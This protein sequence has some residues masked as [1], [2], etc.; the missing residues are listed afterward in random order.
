MHQL[1]KRFQ[2]LEAGKR[3]ALEEVDA[4]LERHALHY[5]IDSWGN[6]RVHPL[7]ARDVSAV[8]RVDGS[9][10]SEGEMVGKIVALYESGDLWRLRQC[11]TEN[12]GQWFMA[13]RKDNRWHS[14][15]CRRKNEKSV[16]PEVR[17]ADARA[18]YYVDG[19][20][21]QSSKR[22]AKIAELILKGQ[23]SPAWNKKL[24]QAE[25]K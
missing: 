13:A 19:P 20:G 24:K 25:R 2:E 8:R 12:C 14:I 9:K 16:S 21:A 18:A 23:C 7:E 6:V 3:A 17:N 15:P 22:D 10:C 4:M 11:E 5:G 1:L